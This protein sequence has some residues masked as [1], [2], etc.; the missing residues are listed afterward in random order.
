MSILLTLQVRNS[1]VLWRN[2]Y[3]HVHNLIFIYH[4][5]T[6]VS[7]E[8]TEESNNA[9][10]LIPRQNNFGQEDPQR[11]SPS[12]SDEIV[13]ITAVFPRA[14]RLSRATLPVVLAKG[15]RLS[16]EHFGIVFS[17]IEEGCA[18][19]V[20]KKV[21]RLSVTRHRIKRR[22]LEALRTLPLPSA[23][24]VCINDNWIIVLI[25]ITLV[26]IFI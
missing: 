19:V 3:Y 11:A 1:G 26:I 6:D 20:S 13:R 25:I 16:S 24:V 5:E 23:L 9:R 22:V 4:A 7:A 10:I 21:A 2:C 17:E 12:W 14:K 18:V 8:K 15:K